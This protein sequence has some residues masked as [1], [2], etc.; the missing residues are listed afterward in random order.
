[1]FNTRTN[2]KIKAKIHNKVVTH[3]LRQPNLEDIH[4]FEK[5]KL[6]YP[7]EIKKGEIMQRDNTTKAYLKLWTLLAIAV[8]GYKYVGENWKDK[9]P[10]LHKVPMAKVFGNGYILDEQEVIDQFGKDRLIAT[11]DD[12]I[13]LYFTDKQKGEELLMTHEFRPPTPEDDEEF[14]R[15][16]SLSKAKTKKNKVIITNLPTT[17]AYCALYDSMIIKTN[18]YIECENCN[19]PVLHKIVLIKELF[20]ALNEQMEEIEGN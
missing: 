6:S 1:M 11:E 17:K 9:V 3:T 16:N 19:V 10:T 20:A 12:N 8:E 15:I 5:E 14:N 7:M 4:L 13:V 2:Y 18:G